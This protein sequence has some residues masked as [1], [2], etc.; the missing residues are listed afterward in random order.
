M[1]TAFYLLYGLIKVSFNFLASLING[2]ADNYDYRSYIESFNFLASLINGNF[3]KF[4]TWSLS[5]KLLTS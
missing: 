3:W 1:E 2:N 4:R 5:S